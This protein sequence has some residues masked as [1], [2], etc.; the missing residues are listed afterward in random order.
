MYISSLL[1]KYIVSD[2]NLKNDFVIVPSKKYFYK[3]EAACYF[4]RSEVNCEQVIIFYT[5]NTF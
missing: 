5:I 4:N 2:K 1:R 3:L